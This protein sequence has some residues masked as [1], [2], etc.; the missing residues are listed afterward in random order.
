MRT[1]LR[2]PSQREMLIDMKARSISV[3]LAFM[4]AGCAYA[5]A[6]LH[7]T[8]SE[9]NNKTGEEVG[10][11]VEGLPKRFAREGVGERGGGH[12]SKTPGRRVSSRNPT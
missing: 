8:I 4:L 1:T 5:Q 7:R 2:L 6:I 9:Y 10:E 12:Q 11:V 3:V